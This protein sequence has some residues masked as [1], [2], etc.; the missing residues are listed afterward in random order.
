MRM[1]LLVRYCINKEGRGMYWLEMLVKR[2]E[3]R[4]IYRKD[5][6]GGS[7]YFVNTKYIKIEGE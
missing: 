1:R 4:I 2:L 6:P 5:C 7:I 3:L